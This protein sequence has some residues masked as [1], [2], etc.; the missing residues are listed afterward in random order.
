MVL[1]DEILDFLSTSKGKFFVFTHRTWDETI[2]DEI[3]RE[4]FNY[5]ESLHKTTDEMNDDLVHIQYWMTQRDNYGDVTIVIC[6]DRKVYF[7]Y[8]DMIRKINKKIDLEYVL[9]ESEPYFGEDGDII[10]KLSK[11]YI[12]G[13]FNNRTGIITPNPNFNPSYDNPK[14]KQKI[15][16]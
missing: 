14:Y 5:A 8:F 10:Y 3:L 6:I 2:A 4:G 11:H 12:K 1:S 13:Y 15:T 9:S 7:K 16:F